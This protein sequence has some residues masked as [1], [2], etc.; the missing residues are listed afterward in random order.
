M[1]QVD[2]KPL[3]RRLNGF[4]TRSLEAAAGQCVS[5]THYEVTVEHML[6]KMAE[7]PGADLARILEHFEIE[8]ARVR[9]SLQKA[10]ESLRSGNAGKPVFS[11]ILVQWIQDGWMLSSID[12]SLAEVRSGALVAALV[13]QPERYLTGDHPELA[14]IQAGELRRRFM[15]VVAGSVEEARPETAVP[16]GPRPAAAAAGG[17]PGGAESALGRFAINFTEKARR[18][19]IDPVF[20]RDR[21]IRQ[22]VDILAR[23]RK[24]NPIVVGEAGVGKTAVVEGLALRVVEGDVPDLLKGVEIFGLDMGLLQAGA[25]V[26]GEFENRLK[27]LITE[28]KS[29]PTPIITFIDEAHTLIGA[30]GSPGGS[31]A[32]NLLKPAL[33]RGE[34]RTIAATTWAEYKKY[35]EEDPALARR[36]QLVKLEEPSVDDA[37]LILRGL[38]AKYEEVHKVHIRDDAVDAAARMSARYLAGRQLPDKAVDLLDTASARV[39]IGLSSRPGAVEDLQRRI[40]ALE[41]ELQAVEAEGASGGVVDKK[42][43]AEIGEKLRSA[44]EELGTIEERWR[45]EKEAVDRVLDLRKRLSGDGVPGASKGEPAPAPADA[46]KTTRADLDSAMTEL[47]KLQGRDPMIRL[48]VDPEVVAHVVGDW[49]GIPVG[50]MVQDDA[51]AILGL[52]SRLKERIKGQDHAMQTISQVLRSA[53]AG[54]GDPGK[55]MGVFLLAGPSGVGKTETALTVADQIFGGER[56]TVTI[57][58]SEYQD[59]EMGV[60]GLVGARPGYVGYGKG[61]VLTEAVRQRPYTVVLLDEMEK[62]ASEVR[63]VFFQVFDKGELTDGTGRTID[64]KNTVIFITTNVGLETIQQLCAASAAPD[65]AEILAAIRP[66]LSKVFSPAW[67]ART[68]VIPYM[69]LPVDALRGITALKMSKVARRLQESHRLELVC[70]D[71]VL[72]RIAERCTEVETGARNIDFILQGTLLPRISAAILERMATG[73]LPERL[74]VKAG[75]DGDFTVGFPEA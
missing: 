53:K 60:S 62:A 52:E 6:L 69:T 41:R 29:S 61:G 31:D 51:S 18:G 35:V 49:T 32:A 66:T 38:R 70:D 37:A 4:C 55:P 48:E 12:L 20:G 33:A 11:P 45:K 72:D 3:L 21:E 36:F 19:E 7:D 30:G 67:L 63:N 58:M 13:A 71:K 44:K 9:R 39:K 24:N 73:P 64:F 34:L 47:K 57:N 17:R 27:N 50:K 15:D 65:A 25:G 59:G 1:V 16:G 43:Q 68:T 28:I 75:E 22:M 54:L 56:F 23:R 2:L 40:Q 26:K 5:S 74:T 46:P 42:R 10:I 8:P 14:R